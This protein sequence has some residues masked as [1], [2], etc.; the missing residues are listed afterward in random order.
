[1]KA[2]RVTTFG[3]P[4]VLATENIDDL[5]PGDDQILVQIHAA[6]INPVDSYIVSGKYARKPGLPFTP[7]SDG[8][9]VV[10]ETGKDVTSVKTGDRVYLSGSITGSLAEQALCTVN[11]VHPLP[12]DITFPQGAAVGIPYATAYRAIFQKAHARPGETIL[13]H[14]ASGGVGLAATQIALHA[15]LRIIATAGSDEG[16]KLVKKQGAHY[17]I[18]HNEKDHYDKALD[19]TDGK[20][21]DLI[22]EMLANVN[23]DGDLRLLA[24]GG[25]VIVIG[26]KD[27][28]EINP[29][30]LMIRDS[31]IIGMLLFNASPR[32]LYEI[33]S[34]L[35]AGLS[36]GMLNPVI[37]SQFPLDGAPK[38]FSEMM[39]KPSCGK[40]VI[41]C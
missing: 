25:K 16:L 12:D 13:I 10:L 39:N 7:G 17:I 22:L 5:L 31:S 29:R 27:T 35:Y 41:L 6:G 37:Q 9:G 40:I 28:I 15:G 1:M 32:A 24:P 11:Q 18:N 23:L 36:T 38:A 4:D 3:G 21:A 8:A 20:G 33:H 26:S 30:D 19:I 2:I 14:G 34:A